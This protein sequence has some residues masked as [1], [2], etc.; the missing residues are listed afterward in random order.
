MSLLWGIL[1]TACRKSIIF[2]LFVKGRD[3]WR[4]MV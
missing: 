3:I 2:V 4:G 1:K